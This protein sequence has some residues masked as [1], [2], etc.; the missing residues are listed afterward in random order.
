ML[1][2]DAEEIPVV[3]SILRHVTAL[4]IFTA[5]SSTGIVLEA[6]AQGDVDTGKQLYQQRCAPCHGPD[7]K[8]NTPTA[9]A[10]NPKPRDHTDGVYMNQLSPE[11]LFKVIKQGGTAVGKSPIMPPQA[12]LNDKQV[13]DIIV[14]VRSLASPPYKGD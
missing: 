13:Q 14:F 10:L 7:G 6:T 9:Q 12:D 2:P 8:A 3:R 11:H 4:L 5:F 1:E